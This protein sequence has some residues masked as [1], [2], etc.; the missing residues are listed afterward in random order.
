MPI[1]KSAKKRMRQTKRRT[2][3]LLPVRSHMKTMMK[4]VLDLAQA[5]KKE[6]AAKVLH[7]AYKAV[8]LAAKKHIIHW[9]NAAR[10]KSRMSKAVAGVGKN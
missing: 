5:G 8:D 9:K 2:E 3:R 10:K 1:I 4:K 6:E 7:E